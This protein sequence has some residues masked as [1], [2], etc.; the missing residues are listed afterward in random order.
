MEPITATPRS[1]PAP[2]AAPALEIT[3]LS[4]A[5]VRDRP[6]LDAV[7]LTV[8]SG[9]VHALAGANGSGKSTLVKILAGYHQAG[10]GR[11]SVGGVELPT[12]VR[13]ATVR[14]AGV[15]FVHQEKGF[16][17]GMSVLDNMCLGRSY[18]T[19]RGGR[20]DWRIE[21]AQIT[22]E[23]ERHQVEVRLDADA[24]TLAPAERAKL[25]I[26]RAMHV[27]AGERRRLVVLDEA[28]AAMAGEE[29]AALGT[30]LRELVERER[31]S[32]LF[33]GHRPEELREIGDR[34]SVLRA[35]KIAAT[36]DAAAATNEMIVEAIVG[37][38]IGSFYPP[39]V[40]GTTEPRTGF[41]VE[42]LEGTVVAG[43]SFAINGGE[44]VGV[45]GIEGSGHEEV[46]YL[47]FDPQ[48][49]GRGTIV[50]QG[51]R[52]AIGS[53]TIRQNLRDGLVLVPADRAKNGLVG[54]LTVREN[55]A[56]P[57]L[58]SFR[59][60]GFLSRRLERGAADEVVSSYGVSPAGSEIRVA[61]MSGGNQ[62]KVLLGKWVAMSPRALLL[63]EPTEGIDVMTKREI[64]R[65]LGE[66][67][68]HGL[69]V[70]LS[71]IEYEDLAHV[72]D[73]ILVCGNGRIRAELHG[74]GLTGADVMSAAYAASFESDV[75]V[76][77]AAW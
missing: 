12:Q 29:A 52:H 4:K 16:I 43:M 13:P 70:V 35:G 75:P 68:K 37:T 74:G 58:A 33:I 45:T 41:A 17:A 26:I 65:I 25:A 44:I 73:R 8:R 21:R 32:V 5:F 10:S 36:F 46:P 18:A 50:V 53:R 34:I 39:R 30:W 76:V 40:E 22:A 62:Q 19:G 3:Q 27:R 69:A 38:S 72:C 7:N 64:F 54:V 14:Q 67:K 60:R 66:Q 51:Q 57:R 20:I 71:S 63:H 31:L 61:T 56:Q 24:G 49:G 1:Q 55:V 9:E 48:R 28:T 2:D 11:I 77:S 6:V 42:N 47:V 59:R 15:R 23:L